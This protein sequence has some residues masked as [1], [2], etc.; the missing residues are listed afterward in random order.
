MQMLNGGLNKLAI[1]NHIPW[2]QDNGKSNW[3]AMA[4]ADECNIKVVCRVRPMNNSELA[5]GSVVAVKFQNEDT[6]SMGVSTAGSRMFVVMI[7]V[8]KLYNID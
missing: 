7:I 2:S 6:V 4:D 3:F 5:S 8:Y 1:W